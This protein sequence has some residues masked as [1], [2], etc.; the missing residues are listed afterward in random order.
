MEAH[1]ETKVK[2]YVKRKHL[3]VKPIRCY[4][5]TKG[6]DFAEER[7][8]FESELT[9]TMLR[10]GAWKETQ[11]KNYNFEAAG[12]PSHGGH[13]HPLMRVRE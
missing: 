8:K 10:S 12:L 13:L 1:D 5:V 2:N 3:N 6:T 4:K 11:F 7:V 9:A